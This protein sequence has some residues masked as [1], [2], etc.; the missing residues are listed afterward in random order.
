MGALF[1]VC[2]SSQIAVVNPYWILEGADGKGCSRIPICKPGH[3][4]AMSAL[5]T[6]HYR[7]AMTTNIETNMDT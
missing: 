3:T 7:L 6:C 2:R 5:I 4:V 1:K